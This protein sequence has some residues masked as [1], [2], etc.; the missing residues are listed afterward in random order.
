MT[1][2]IIIIEIAIAA[3][4]RLSSRLRPCHLSTKDYG[5][6]TAKLLRQIAAMLAGEG[7]FDESLCYAQLLYYLGEAI[8]PRREEIKPAVLQ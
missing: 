1:A 4:G 8:E 5:E 7:G 6:L 2:P 3:D